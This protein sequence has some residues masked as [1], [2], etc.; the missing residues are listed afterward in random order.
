MRATIDFYFDFSSSYS[1]IALPRLARLVDDHGCQVN[2]K[3]I[4][5]GV[6]FKAMNHAPPAA[7]TT[8]GRYVW[9]DVERSAQ[10]AGLSFK[11]P[12]A[13]P[14]NSMTAAR[15]FWYVADSDMDKAVEWARAVFHASFGEGRDCSNPEVLAAVAVDMGLDAEEVLQA[16]ASD[17]VK[18]RLKQVTG[19][20]ME[21][22]VFGAP[23]FFAGDE[24][25]WGGDRIDQLEHYVGG[26]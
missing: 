14:F 2:W 26:A 4:A 23:T 5:L 24:M 1:Y 16:T 25:F 6:I 3:P 8:K 21:R 10:L 17:T 7:D 12:E 22:G 20:A 11:W 18:E 19:E 9:R 13:F 15:I